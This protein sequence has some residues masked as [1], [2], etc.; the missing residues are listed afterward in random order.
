[1]K[2]T[3]TLALIALT[4][5]T[6]I[7]S[8]SQE[9]YVLEQARAKLRE[10]E[11]QN[12]EPAE[13]NT[14][15]KDVDSPV[16]QDPQS[17]WNEHDRNAA[18][19]AK[20]GKKT[21]KNTHPTESKILKPIDSEAEA[22][23]EVL[24]EVPF[25]L[26]FVPGVPSSYGHN[27]VLFGLGIIGSKSGRINGLQA[28]GIFSLSGDVEGIQS[29]G[30]FSIARGEVHGVQTAGIFNIASDS[31]QGVQYA[32]IF[33]IVAGNAEGV[34]TAGIFNLANHISGIQA[35]GI[36]N[37]AKSA[38]GIQLGLVNIAGKSRGL[39]LGL[40]SI[41]SNGVRQVQGSWSNADTF[42]YGIKTGSPSSF[43]H[44]YAEMA[45]EDLWQSSESLVLGANMGLRFST[46]GDDAN[47]GGLYLDL[48]AGAKV[49][50]GG[51]DF[52]IGDTD[53]DHHDAEASA[54]HAQEFFENN[55]DR[56]A[57]DAVATL[58]FTVERSFGL[59]MGVDVSMVPGNADKLMN[60]VF[61]S[62]ERFEGTI[63]G[64]SDFN[65]LGSTRWF[66]GLSL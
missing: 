52:I 62:G 35:A 44:L 14:P 66:F 25:A 50:V 49:H 57:F 26:E 31:L 58:G 61:A 41:N 23:E 20:T 11:V 10:P 15:A 13:S 59:F 56:F 39:S 48:E 36:V 9:D 60:P 45:K 65:V 32:G 19:D 30:I 1:M 37:I 4:L 53:F 21:G 12:E 3:M 63:C 40:L 7:F 46:S 8:Q 38:D 22:T 54:R 17:F 51:G 34:Q 33:N 28:S 55:K 2:K 5:I 47:E 6:R 27:E 42:R 18:E 43:T 16:T 29:G 24:D 64:N